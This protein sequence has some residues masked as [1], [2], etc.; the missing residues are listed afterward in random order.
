VNYGCT[1]LVDTEIWK[2][3]DREVESTI[4]KRTIDVTGGMVTPRRPPRI[5]FRGP[6]I[7]QGEEPGVTQTVATLCV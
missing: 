5:G 1:V 4:E 3:I 2:Q 6:H 7:I